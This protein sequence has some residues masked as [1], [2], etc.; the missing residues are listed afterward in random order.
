[1][2]K[3]RIIKSI[4]SFFDVIHADMESAKR[5]RALIHALDLLAM[6]YHYIKSRLGERGYPNT[7]LPKENFEEKYNATY[8]MM[9]R[10]FPDLG[11][12]Y[13][14]HDVNDEIFATAPTIGDAID[15]LTDIYNELKNVMWYFDN[16]SDDNALSYFEM[17]YRTH[18]EGH[19]REL[20]LCLGAFR[21]TG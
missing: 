16:A 11:Y 10:K 3:K 20:Q 21:A 12:Y 15:D 2:N 13:V 4:N 18:W 9:G 7:E 14:E 6:E 8:Q 1:M 19:L 5:I 17:S